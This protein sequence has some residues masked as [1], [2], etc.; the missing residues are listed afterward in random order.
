MAGGGWWLSE[1]SRVDDSASEDASRRPDYYLRSFENTIHDESG[2]PSRMLSGTEMRHYPDDDS[3]ELDNPHLILI[4]DDGA[5][6]T[7]NAEGGKLSGDGNI[8]LLDGKVEIEKG[9]H[10]GIVPIRIE[11]S[12]LL[13]YPERN[14]AETGAEIRIT[15]GDNWIH[16]TGMKVWFQSPARIRL[17]SNVRGQYEIH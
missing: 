13:I 1:S 14:L 11:T 17:L 10:Q 15:S 12:D 3:T 9:A 6:W 5:R 7:V 2:K 4:D 16:S 8:L